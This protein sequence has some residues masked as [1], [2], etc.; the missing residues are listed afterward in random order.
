MLAVSNNFKFGRKRKG[1]IN[2]LKKFSY[3]YGYNLLNIHPFKISKKIV[4]STIIRK[5]LIKGNISLANKLLSRT[6]FVDGVV[7]KGQ[8]IGRQLGYRTCNINIKKYILPKFGIYSVKI[9]IGETKNI[10]GGVAYL[11]SRPTFNGKEV[12]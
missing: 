10:D 1:N 12:F 4:S 5:N 6:W 3:I 11:V 2:L 9:L 7:E 8:K